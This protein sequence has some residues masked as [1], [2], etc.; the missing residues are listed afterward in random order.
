MR[1]TGLEPVR[2][3][4][5]PLKRACLPIPA[6]PHLLFFSLNSFVLFVFRVIQ[7]NYYSIYFFYCQGFFQK[8]STIYKYT[9]HI[10]ICIC[11]S[12]AIDKSVRRYNSSVGLDILNLSIPH[13]TSTQPCKKFK[14]LRCPRW[15][16]F[17]HYEFFQQK[18]DFITKSF[19]YLCKLRIT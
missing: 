7:L 12:F 1:Q 10:L 6:L 19:N 8:N 2:Q 16:S 18:K 5:T 11:L 9:Y 15:N 14:Q 3:G 13:G 17:T 4:H